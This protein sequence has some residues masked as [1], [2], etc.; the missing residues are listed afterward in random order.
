MAVWRGSPGA[1]AASGVWLR[2]AVRKQ[3]L[4]SVLKHR[5]GSARAAGAPG[6]HHAPALWEKAT[7]SLVLREEKGWA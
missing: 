6:G 1:V 5:P 3:C 4:Q 7:W 2:E